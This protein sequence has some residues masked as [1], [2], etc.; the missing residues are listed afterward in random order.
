MITNKIIL[1]LAIAAMFTFLIWPYKEPVEISKVIVK[2][3]EKSSISNSKEIKVSKMIDKKLPFFLK[4]PAS[5]EGNRARPLTRKEVA[6]YQKAK[7]DKRNDYLL[8]SKYIESEY[9]SKAESKIAKLE[10]QIKAVEEKLSEEG[11]S[12]EVVEKH[13]NE[14]VRLTSLKK[15]EEVWE[16]YNEVFLQYH[17]ARLN[18][19][20]ARIAEVE[21]EIKTI[22]TEF[23]KLT[24]KNFPR[25]SSIFYSMNRGKMPELRKKYLN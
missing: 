15:A 25:I 22:E 23:K 13:T 14:M 16:E 7:D 12:Q 24:Q 18:K 8:I 17:E 6:A 10:R 4:L 9:I 19:E 2:A 21:I 3:E 20:Y 5:N 11:L 1:A